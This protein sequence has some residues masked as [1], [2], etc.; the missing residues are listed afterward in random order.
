MPSWRSKSIER[1]GLREVPDGWEGAAAEASEDA[2]KRYYLRRDLAVEK[3]AN[4]DD[5]EGARDVLARWEIC[6]NAYKDETLMADVLEHSH[7]NQRTCSM[8]RTFLF[9]ACSEESHVFRRELLAC[10]LWIDGH[11]RRRSRRRSTWRRSR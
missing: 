1:F 4:V 6:S 8:L 2:W 3:R 5:C 11:D 7:L 9:G 10:A